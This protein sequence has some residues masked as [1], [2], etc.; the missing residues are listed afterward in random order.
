VGHGQG[1]AARRDRIGV[2]A[3]TPQRW[4]RVKEVLGGALELREEERLAFLQQ[5]CESDPGLREEVERLLE[6]EGG[7]LEN[8]MLD[9][10][11]NL[12]TPELARDEM[13][14]PYRSVEKGRRGG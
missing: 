12:A 5:S 10:L 3:M 11:A 9:A 7:P 2:G 13:V 8:P 1:M 14:G 4:A 6:A